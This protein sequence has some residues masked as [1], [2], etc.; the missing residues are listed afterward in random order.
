MIFI[1]EL[2]TFNMVILCHANFTPIKKKKKELW[3]FLPKYVMFGVAEPFCEVTSQ[4]QTSTVKDGGVER[5]KEPGL[6]YITVKF[7]ELNI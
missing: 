3:K 7:W 1:F 6:N 4:G 2:L 5:W